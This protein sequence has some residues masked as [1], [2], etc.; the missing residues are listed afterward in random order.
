MAQDTTA[1]NGS[2]NLVPSHEPAPAMHHHHFPAEAHEATLD[3]VNVIFSGALPRYAT[4]LDFALI[5]LQKPDGG[6]CPIANGEVWYRVA[7]LC[8]LEACAG[9][10]GALKPLQLGVGV[11]GGVEAA[12]HILLSALAQ[13][14]HVM[15]L[16]L[17]VEN[18][19]NSV[20]QAAVFAVVR[21]RILQLLT[22]V[23]WAYGVPTILH[24]AGA[25][26]HDKSIQS[27]TGVRQGDPLGMLL[28]A[29][30]QH[31][32]ERAADG[33]TI[34]AIADDVAI[35]G[36]VDPLRTAFTASRATRAPSSPAQQVS[37]CDRASAALRLAER[38]SAPQQAR[39]W[40]RSWVSDGALRA[41]LS[42]V[43]RSERTRT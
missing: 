34:V 3:V 11:S 25:P 17:D 12:G 35:A 18:A 39:R 28:F 7:T 27:Q 23:Q 15:A 43:H 31:S 6:L 37:A 40:R 21:D 10:G 5:G 20:D 13:D 38:P 32:L 14:D 42:R 41:P 29:V 1:E 2:R 24:V 16:L 22:F 19:F 33:A 8:A 36:R 26:S 4:L 30:A 9:A